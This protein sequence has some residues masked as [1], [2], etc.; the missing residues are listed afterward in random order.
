MNDLQKARRPAGGPGDAGTAVRGRA[1]SSAPIVADS[2][3]GVKSLAEQAAI[4]QARHA[5][6]AEYH[7]E[8]ARLWLEWGHLSPWHARQYFMHLDAAYWHAALATKH[9]ILAATLEGAGS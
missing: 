9:G 6:E 7:Y 8:R 5:A 1:L 4:L 2:A 3:R